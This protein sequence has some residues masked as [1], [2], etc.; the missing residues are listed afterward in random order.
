LFGVLRCM[1]AKRGLYKKK[2]FGDLRHLKYGYG[3][4]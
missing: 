2:I 1:E 3:G 4:K